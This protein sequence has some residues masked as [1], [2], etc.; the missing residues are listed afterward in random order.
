LRRPGK[1]KKTFRYQY[2]GAAAGAYFSFTSA[3]AM[4]RW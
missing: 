1:T 4:T 2:A 3:E